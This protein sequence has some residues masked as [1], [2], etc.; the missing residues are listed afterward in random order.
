MTVDVSALIPLAR[1][2]RAATAAGQVKWERLDTPE[3]EEAFE[4]SAKAGTARITRHE[5]PSG[6]AQHTFVLLN[7]Q[8]QLVDQVDTDPTIPGP[9]RAWEKDLHRLHA[10]AR[11]AS[12]DVHE[13]VQDLEKEWALP[14]D[15]GSEEDIPF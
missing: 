5:L 6:A 2:L 10:A 7:A 13:V 3:N 12:S 8:G 14:P 15:P 1:R 4:A 11:L 9:W